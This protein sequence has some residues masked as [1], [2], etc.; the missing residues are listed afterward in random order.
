MRLKCFRTLGLR[1]QGIDMSAN[2][3]D[4]KLAHN[5]FGK[6]EVQ[7]RIAVN[8]VK[9]IV[10]D[11]VTLYQEF[12]KAE[13]LGALFFNPAQPEASTYMTV[14]DIRNDITLA[15][16][17]LD[18]DLKDFLTKVMNVI[19]KE[20]DNNIA[21]VVLVDRNAMS[22]RLIDLNVAED[23]INELANAVSRD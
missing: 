20:Q 14:P 17:I 11:I 10:G 4:S 23:R 8:A 15:E 12:R 2:K 7:N 21:V 13:G 16:E 5:I 22:I 1:L 9:M 18:E 3:P 19:H 6:S